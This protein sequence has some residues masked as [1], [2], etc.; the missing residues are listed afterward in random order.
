MSCQRNMI[1]IHVHIL[2]NVDDGPSTLEYA[3]AMA[4]VAVADGVAE[5]VATPHNAHWRGSGFR[6]WTGRQVDNLQDELNRRGIPLK[7]WPGTEVYIDLDLALQMREERAFTLNGSRYL[8]LE[9]GFHTWPSY[10]EQ[11]C[12][13]LQQHGI[14]PILAHP[15]RY[16]AV[17]RN[18]ALVYP[19]VERGVLTQLTAGSIAGDFGPRVRETARILLDHNLV[20]II[21]SDAHD[22]W[23]RQPVLSAGVKAAAE[24]V[25]EE[26][27]WA[28]VTK[29]PDLVLHDQP[30]AMEPPIEIKP[31]QRWFWI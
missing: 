16:L 8:L 6:A 19:L 29:V 2:P 13:E 27:A 21:A 23:N 9:L 20:H 10:T 25:G 3:V 7:L 1:D 4:E 22:A 28:M 31:R 17:Q 11:V 26:R 18:P 15:A 30:V 24:I 5:V 14:C 12:A